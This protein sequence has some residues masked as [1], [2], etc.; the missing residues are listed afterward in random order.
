MFGVGE[1]VVYGNDGVC[2]VDAV[3]SLNMDG[4]Q[5]EKQYY[6]LLPV[7]FGGTK[8][9]CPVESEKV[10]LRRIL[11]REE[12]DQLI[13]EIP[14]MKPLEVSDERARENVYKS[15]LKT[16]DCHELVRLI[17]TVHSRREKRL[18]GGKK[19]TAVDEKYF[20]VAE[21]QL[22]GEL[23]IPLAIDRSEVRR[24]ISE[25]IEKEETE[26]SE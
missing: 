14:S 13:R 10:V 16:C 5:T 8:V 6:T 21:D 22:Y 1:Y 2:K 7:Y 24:Y 11:S 3:G 25:Q 15:A 4:R 12:T 20:R 18:S 23:A 19:V 9:Y 26:S 17:K